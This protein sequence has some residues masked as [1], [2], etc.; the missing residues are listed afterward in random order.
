MSQVLLKLDNVSLIYPVLT[1]QAQSIR[2]T[3]IN[4][5]TG[6]KMMK[7][8]GN[9]VHV[10][11][12]QKINFELLEGDR[13]GIIGHNGSGKTTLLKVLAGIYCPT[14]G[15]VLA[16]GN[17]SSM[18]DLGTG[19]DVDA[20]GYENIK[21]VGRLRGL[22]SAQINEQV[23]EIIEFADL[24]SFIDLPVNTYSSGMI[25]RLLFS[26]STSFNPDILVLDEWLGAGD[27]DFV[28]KAEQRMEQFVANSR[29]LV[30]AS[31]DHNMIQRR[32]N[33]LLVLEKGEVKFF[34]DTAEWY[35]DGVRI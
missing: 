10:R 7:N 22:S 19:I 4:K 1:V 5:V 32:C 18:I 15:Q 24:G 3:L 31:H 25:M 29:L 2:H 17:V 21:M 33:K 16:A 28:A 20:T 27:V 8:S 9:V 35:K 14:S 11:A 13:L 6:G 34:G 26:I 23:D 12:L 30:I